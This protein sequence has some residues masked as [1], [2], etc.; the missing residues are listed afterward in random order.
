MNLT[1]KAR[2]V[3]VDIN[4]WDY[5]KLKS[6]WTAKETNKTKRP[7][8]KWKKILENNSTDKRLIS[9]ICKELIQLNTKLTH[10]PAIKWVG[11]R[12]RHLFQEDIEMASRSMKRCSTSLAIRKIEIKTTMT[13]HPTP[14]R[15]ATNN[16]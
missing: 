2:K 15:K 4:E 10:S 8:T 3:K 16:K 11:H 7:P 6:F 9:R 14:T 5:I 13:Y 1:S 12:N